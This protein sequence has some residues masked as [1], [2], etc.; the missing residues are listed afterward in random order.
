VVKVGGS[1]PDEV[2][3]FFVICLI[4]PAALG[5]GVYSSSNRNE[6][7]KEKI[8]FLGSRARL[9]PNADN[10]SEVSRQCRILNMSQPCRPPGPVTRI[11]G[12]QERDSN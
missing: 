1:R 8:M 12:E 2:N 10:L 9:M 5:P 3:A 6:C 11:E 4:L 7:R